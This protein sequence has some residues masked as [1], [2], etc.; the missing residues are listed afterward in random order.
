MLA[1]EAAFQNS[2]SPVGPIFLVGTI[3]GFV[4]GIMISYQILYTDLSDQMPQY[5]TLKAMG[6]E[7]SYLTRVVLQQAGFYALVGF[8]PALALGIVIYHVI[9]EIALLPLHMTFSIALGTLALTLAMCV[10]SG[11]LAVRRVL[12]LDPAEVF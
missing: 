3:I 9:G 7:G 10:F 6:Y 2:V 11:I 1:L 4:V 5:A 8:G 12:A